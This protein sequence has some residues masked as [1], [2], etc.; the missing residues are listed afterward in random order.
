MT[1]IF[2]DVASFRARLRDARTGGLAIGF[3]PTMGALH[4]GHLTLV[5]EAK[6]HAPF[7][8]ATIFVNP[9]QFGPNEDLARYPRDL[10]GDVAKLAS[11]GCDAVLAPPVEEMYPAGERTRV[12][13]GALGDTLCGP[14]R[15]GHFEGVATV[16]TKLFAIAGECVAVFGRKDYQQLAIIRRLATDLLLPVTVVGAR[17]V[18]DPDGLAMSSRNAYLSADERRHALALAAGLRAAHALFSRGERSATALREAAAAPVRAVATSIDYVDVADPDTLSIHP[19][20]SLVHE[21]TLIAIAARIGK[22]RLIDNVV[23]GEE[24]AP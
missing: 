9:T 10:D 24:E 7:V 12:T 4:D 17:T 15:P 8:T 20:G 6:R 2:R 21:R 14:H 16:V 13:V 23:A 18:R 5:R 1:E 19:D 3:V 22:T 11:V